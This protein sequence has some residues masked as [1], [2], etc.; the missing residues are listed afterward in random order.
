MKGFRKELSG[1]WRGEDVPQIP[2][3]DIPVLR[4]QMVWQWWCTPL[5]PALGR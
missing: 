5:I 3:T 1:Y 4:M 2:E